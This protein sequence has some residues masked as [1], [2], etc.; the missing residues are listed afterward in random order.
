MISLY[1]STRRL[2]ED[3][4]EAAY[5]YAACERQLI[6]LRLRAESLG[7]GVST[8][9]VGGTHAHDSMERRVV[10]LADRQRDIEGRMLRYERV[11]D[12]A[13][14]MLY[15]KGGRDGLA[16]LVPAFWCDALWWHYLQGMTW[17]EVGSTLGYSAQHLKRCATAAIEVGD[18]YGIV[19]ATLGEGIAEDTTP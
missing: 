19:A 1:D 14:D 5:D 12:M 7:G 16:A 3:A 11:M 10:A 17:V 4:R 18:A 6:A 2:L 9:S 8:G 15:G 13:C